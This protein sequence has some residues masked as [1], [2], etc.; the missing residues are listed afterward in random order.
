M[1]KR[2]WLDERTENEKPWWN[3][4]VWVFIAFAI[5]GAI[6]VV[7]K[8]VTYKKE[9]PIERMKNDWQ[10]VGSSM[11]VFG[12][13]SYT[14]DVF[15]DRSSLQKEEGKI[16]LWVKVIAHS[17]VIT[18][19]GNESFSWDEQIARWIVNCEG[20]EVRMDYISLSFKGKKQYDGKIDDLNLPIVKG[21]TIHSI[22]EMFCF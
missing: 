6:K 10:P 21:T 8:E 22:Y 17:P 14:G 1:K 16:T 9:I 2:W 18:P 3:K 11:M 7:Y 13:Q 4:I 15:F 5:A 12:G 19:K 20:K